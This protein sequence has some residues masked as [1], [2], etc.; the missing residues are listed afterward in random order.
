[1]PGAPNCYCRARQ[2]VAAGLVGLVPTSLVV[3]CAEVLPR[4]AWESRPLLS[5]GTPGSDLLIRWCG[6]ARC[7]ECRSDNAATECGRRS[8]SPPS[9]GDE[10][11]AAGSLVVVDA[12][13]RKEQGDMARRHFEVID[14]VKVL[15]HWHAG[16]RIE[17]LSP[18]YDFD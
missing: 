10:R 9:R 4:T 18:S 17:Q 5:T 11:V 13:R 12:S 3:Q 16:G 14:V 15:E 8:N 2:V 6:Y 7:R 1:M